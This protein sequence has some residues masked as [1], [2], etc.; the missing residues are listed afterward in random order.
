MEMRLSTGKEDAGK[1]TVRSILL[2]Y[3]R[4]S[5]SALCNIK[6]FINPGE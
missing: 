1:I 5:G 3:G 4:E 2:N 6:A